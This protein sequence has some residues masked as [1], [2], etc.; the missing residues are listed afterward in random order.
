MTQNL[1]CTIH[2]YTYTVSSRDTVDPSEMGLWNPLMITTDWKP[3]S[4]CIRL[5]KKRKNPPTFSFL[6]Q[7]PFFLRERSQEDPD[8]QLT[9]QLMHWVYMCVCRR[10][11]TYLY[12]A[13]VDGLPSQVVRVVAAEPLFLTKLSFVLR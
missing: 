4:P 6:V 10:T 12:A 8:K 11:R 1:S 13:C 7:V 9:E 2:I 5:R 3:S